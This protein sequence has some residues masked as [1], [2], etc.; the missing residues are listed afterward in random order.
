MS[1]PPV[2][3]DEAGATATHR[4]W[5]R[6]R[7]PFD[8]PEV[9]DA[10]LGLPEDAVD[11]LIGS[12]VASGDAAERL[13]ARMPVIS[14]ALSTTVQ[15]RPER[16]MGELRGPVLWSETMAARGASAA[17]PDVFVCAVPR[18]DYDTDEN[19]ILVAA[20]VAIRDAGRATD[21]LPPDAYDDETLRRARANGQKAA[22]WLHNQHLEGVP[23]TR[24]TRRELRRVRSGSRKGT[25][26][27]ALRLLDEA[28]EPLTVDDLLPYCDRRTRSQHEVLVG[29]VERLEARGQLVPQFRARDAVL[30]AGPVQFRH[31]RQR[32]RRDGLHGV[33]VHDVLVDVPPSG[34]VLRAE[35][36]AQMLAER[37]EGRPSVLVLGDA[38]LDRAVELALGS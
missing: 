12:R 27:P 2:T 16:C 1:V 14:R 26:T 11:Q 35:V 30:T 38:D 29:I 25:Y 31:Q 24:P 4:L 18:R 37:A 8:T 13:L 22:R 6:L 15:K 17:A 9:I 23:R 7:R 36:A 10:V 5:S 33:L 3:V 34:S 19:R 28:Y 20:L 32:G 21:L